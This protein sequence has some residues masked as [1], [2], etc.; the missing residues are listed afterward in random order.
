VIFLNQLD[1]ASTTA[2]TGDAPVEMTPVSGLPQ[3]SPVADKIPKVHEP[4]N[5]QEA[6]NK[7]TDKKQVS[8]FSLFRFATTSDWLLMALGCVA[9]LAGASHH[10]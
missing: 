5:V 10:S 6:A 9:A 1:M 4:S 8:Y 3:E 2:D 7:P